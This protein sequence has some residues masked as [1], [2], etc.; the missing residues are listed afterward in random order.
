MTVI[1][2]AKVREK[3]LTAP[4]NALISAA[5]AVPMAWEAVLKDTPFATGSVM[6]NTLHRIGPSILPNIPVRMIAAVVT[7]GIPPASSLSGIPIAVVMLL[8]SKL[9]V[10]T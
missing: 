5:F 3:L 1:S 8:G 4:V 2:P 9:T 6:R 7:A 10:K